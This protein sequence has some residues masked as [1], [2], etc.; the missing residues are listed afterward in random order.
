MY[1][2]KRN[3]LNYSL[4]KRARDERRLDKLALVGD[5]HEELDNAKN[6]QL[7]YQPQIDLISREVVAVEALLR[8]PHPQL[9]SI[10]PEHIIKMA[11]HTGLIAPLTRW[12][13][14]TTLLQTGH[15][16]QT[17]KP[18]SMAVNLSAW[19]L[20]D[21]QLPDTMEQM[22]EKYDV[23]AGQ[24][25]LE[26][27]ESAMMSDPLR[28]RQIL[29]DMGV[30]LAVDDFGTGFSSLGYLKMLPVHDLKIDRS[31]VINMGGDEND[32]IIVHSII[33][34]AHNLG[35]KVI[36]E[37]VENQQTLLHL[38]QQKCDMAQGFHIAAPLSG[39]AVRQWLQ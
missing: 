15:L 6:L 17:G 37:G 33:E 5:L 14:D 11:E 39:D 9:G 13:I 36:A 30:K 31:F 10:S 24:L 7:Y 18:F 38:Q 23:P 29:S 34:L 19:N 21:P 12:V 20:Q 3:N 32:A 4:Y 25:T 8:W 35:L 1:T 22:L 27:T 16:R 28:A 2:A 26:I